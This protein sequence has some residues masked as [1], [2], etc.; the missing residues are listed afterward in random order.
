MRLNDWQRLGVVLSVV[1]VV[2]AAIHTHNADVERAEDFAKLS[3]KV[4]TDARLLAHDSDL[5]NCIR[6]RAE[7]LQTSMSG[8]NANVAIVAL[9]PIPFGW[10]AAFILLYAGRAQVVG[11]RAVVPWRIL[12]LPRKTFVAFCALTSL[13]AAFLALAWILNLYTDLQVPVALSPFKGVIRTG[14]NWVTVE[15]T[16]TRSGVAAGSSMG[17]PLQTSRIECNK[18]GR[19]CTEARAYVSENLLESD[20][21]EYEVESWTAASIV[22]TKGDLCTAEVF[23]IDLNTEA[24]SGAGHRINKD[25][26]FCKTYASTEERWTYQL[27]N[28]F[29]VYWEQRQKA[30]PLPLRIIQTLFGN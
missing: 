16:W 14:E 15:G 17:Y 30:R 21:V 12:S 18:E 6:K 7:S 25:N 5:S 24:V 20:L 19:R 8:S 22:L 13:A 29:A 3:Y 4:C 26:E 10:L 28:G 27:S 2:G 11:F 23:T 1:W 9:V